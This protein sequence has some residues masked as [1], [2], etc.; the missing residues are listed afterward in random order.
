[1][2]G[3]TGTA[4]APPHAIDRRRRPVTNQHT[5]TTPQHNIGDYA[6]VRYRGKGRTK[7]RVPGRLKV[8]KI[9][10]MYDHVY[11]WVGWGFEVGVAEAGEEDGHRPRRHDAAQTLAPP[12][13][14]CT[15]LHKNAQNPNRSPPA[16]S[17]S[18]PRATLPSPCSVSPTSTWRGS[19]SAYTYT[20]T[21]THIFTR[22]LLVS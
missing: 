22:G 15:T 3:A 5:R 4:A 21:Y 6:V 14:R 13:K 9:E 8:T 12:T 18:T 2:R 7:L 11:T 16:P 19:P 17:S 10:S 20:H 1:M